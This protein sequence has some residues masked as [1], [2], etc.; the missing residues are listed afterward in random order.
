[1]VTSVGVE[2]FKLL[3]HVKGVL[4]SNLGMQDLEQ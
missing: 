2:R 3:R 1:M 4:G